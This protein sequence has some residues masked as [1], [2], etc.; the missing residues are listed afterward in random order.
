MHHQQLLSPDSALDGINEF[1]EDHHH[2]A[3][4]R[5]RRPLVMGSSFNPPPQPSRQSRSRA[6]VVFARHQNPVSKPHRRASTVTA[7]SS[8]TDQSS[9]FDSSRYTESDYSASTAPSLGPDP[10]GEGSGFLPCEFVGFAVCNFQYNLAD[11]E[12]WINHII[13]D[14]LGYRLPQKCACWYCDDYVFDIN[15]NGLDEITN[16]RQRLYHIREHI[17]Y[18]GY[19]ISNIRPDYNFVAHLWSLGMI[20]QSTYDAALSHREGPRSNVTGIYRYDFV[21]PERQYQQDRN[22]SVV[23]SQNTREEK[24][25]GRRER[26]P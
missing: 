5:E 15:E 2:R 24:K 14:H 1:L 23:V 12:Q 16:F 10:Q 3:S 19:G 11:T 7:T 6:P 9:G 8:S 4:S 21:P 26:R 13:D 17:T 22:A 18:N 20:N 25:K